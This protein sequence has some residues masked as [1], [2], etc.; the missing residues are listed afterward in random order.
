MRVVIAGAGRVG[1]TLADRL[2]NRLW[3]ITIIDYSPE[4]CTEIK[5]SDLESYCGDASDPELLE[6]AGAGKANLFFALT[7]NDDVNLRASELALELGADR[8]ISRCESRESTARFEEMGVKTVSPTD[9]AVDVLEDMFENPRVST[10]LHIAGGEGEVMELTL[11]ELSPVVGKRIGELPLE[12]VR[13]AALRKRGGG[14]CIPGDDET[15]EAGDVVV[16]V[17]KKGVISAAT[18]MFIGEEVVFPRGYGET[19]LVPL[20]NESSLDGAL[21]EA[22]AIA[23]FALSS[24]TI[25][26]LGGESLIEQAEKRAKERGMKVKSLGLRSGNLVEE[27]RREVNLTNPALVV[28]DEEEM[29]VMDKILRRKGSATEMVASLPCPVLISKKEHSFDRILIPVDGSEAYE[30]SAEIGVELAS[31]LNSDVLAVAAVPPMRAIRE[32]KVSDAKKSLE[33]VAKFGAL[34]NVDVETRVV[35]GNPVHNI[36]KIVT[37]EGIGLAVLGYKREGDGLFKKA[38]GEK[39]LSELPVSTLIIK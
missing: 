34:W 31:L 25:F 11:S 20:M 29:G 6:E 35:E 8:V 38:V 28:V 30:R 32:Q 7:D 17:G 26:S 23:E 3:D 37:R 16:L 36:S 14:F 27:T 5:Q 19:L 22:L 2:A 15:L 4:R 9:L 1:R 21:V 12:D 13:V 24:I 10:S 33:D 18:H 39:L